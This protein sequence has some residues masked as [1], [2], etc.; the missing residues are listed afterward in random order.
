V[1]SVVNIE[2]FLVPQHHRGKCCV[3]ISS[4]ESA[5][6]SFSEV[7]GDLL[8]YHLAEVLRCRRGDLLRYHL[9]E[10]LRYHLEEKC[11]III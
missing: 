6:L 5:A 4:A 8:R 1:K 11:C 7:R 10:M 3:N 2:P 9:A